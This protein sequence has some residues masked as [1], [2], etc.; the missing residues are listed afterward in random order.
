MQGGDAS[1][2]LGKTLR[3]VRRLATTVSTRQGIRSSTHPIHA[4][5]GNP[6]AW[7]GVERRWSVPGLLWPRWKGTWP[8]RKTCF[9]CE[10][11]LEPALVEDH[12]AGR[13]HQGKIDRMAAVFGLL[14]EELPEEMYTGRCPP[15]QLERRLRNR[16]KRLHCRLC[17]IIA[18]PADIAS[19]L[20]GQKHVERVDRIASTYGKDPDLLPKEILRGRVSESEVEAFMN[21]AREPWCRLCGVSMEPTNPEEHLNG[22]KHQKGLDAIAQS[23]NIEKEDL[24][25]D[26]RNGKIPISELPWMVKAAKPPPDEFE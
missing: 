2:R 22:K 8:R 17:E 6:T 4:N 7:V 9:V 1:F 25:E 5:R 10:M 16:Y 23:Y 3:W 14:P 20:R 13:K 24:P 21:M 15:S 26:F 19:H 11:Q 18:P 12:V